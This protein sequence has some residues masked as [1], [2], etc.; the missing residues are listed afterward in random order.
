M[1]W[2]Q[3]S[4]MDQRVKFIA[5]WLSKEYSKIE[6]CR[7]YGISRPTADKWIKRYKEGG[8]EGL[9]ERSRATHCHP[10]ETAE[11]I[12]EMMKFTDTVAEIQNTL[13]I[14]TPVVLT[15]IETVKI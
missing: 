8:A 15:E 10:N 7:T 12:R 6:L 2:E 5:D 1:P 3:T 13:R 4:A 14:E 11:E 9:E